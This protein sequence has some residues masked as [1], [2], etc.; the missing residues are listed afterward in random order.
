MAA[1]QTETSAETRR[2]KVFRFKRGGHDGEHFDEFVVPVGPNTTVLD[3]LLWIQLHRDRTLALRHS[4]LH[5]SCGTCG[6]LVNRREALACV[7]SASDLGDEV[8]VEPLANI[9]VLADLV[10]DM[11]EFY[12]RFHD[13][14]PIVRTSEFLPGADTP[15]DLGTYLRFEDCLECG[16]CLSACPVASTSQGYVGPAALIAA[17]RLL[18]EPRGTDEQAVLD[19]AAGPE[20]IWRC[21]AAYECTEAC[22]ANVNPAERIMALRREL[23]RRGSRKGQRS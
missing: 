23:L 10:V 2:F 8:T 9:P 20:G 21:H 12:A 5:A 11:D 14:H 3:A 18:E 1:Q 4:C 15:E 7:T 22:P 19:W 16:L 6:V 13:D 17:Q